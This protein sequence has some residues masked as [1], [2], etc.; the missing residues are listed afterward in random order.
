MRAVESQE[1]LKLI[2]E[3]GVCRRVSYKGRISR[4]VETGDPPPVLPPVPGRISR[5]VET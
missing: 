1:G 3:L 4:R 5:R 2:V